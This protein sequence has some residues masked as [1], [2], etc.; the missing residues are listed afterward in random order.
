MTFTFPLINAARQVIIVATGE[1]KEDAFH[2]VRDGA[3][4]LPV[5]RVTA[6]DVEWI[7]DEACAGHGPA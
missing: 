2:S 4:D 6:Q 3:S 7:V 1:D 5:A